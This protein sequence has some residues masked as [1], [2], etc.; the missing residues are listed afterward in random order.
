MIGMTVGA[1][2]CLCSTRS[3]RST[4]TATFTTVKTQSSSRAVVPPSAVRSANQISPK[5][6]NV[7]KTMPTH[8]VRRV[9]CTRPSTLGSTRSLAMP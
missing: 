1:L 2:K 7:V 4:S 6:I 9:R 8:G 5:A 3:R